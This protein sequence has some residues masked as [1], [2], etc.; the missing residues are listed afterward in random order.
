[1]DLREGPYQVAIPD[2]LRSWLL[3]MWFLSNDDFRLAVI[4]FLLRRGNKFSNHLTDM[5]TDR[6]SPIREKKYDR[7][8]SGTLHASRYIKH[9]LVD[10]AKKTLLKKT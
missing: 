4:I 6:A 7:K 9:H 5:G 8:A 10:W 3:H 1:M 2:D